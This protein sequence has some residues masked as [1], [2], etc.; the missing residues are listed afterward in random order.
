M[1]KEIRNG[2]NRVVF[3]MSSITVMAPRRGGG[4][5]DSIG[6]SRLVS[7]WVLLVAGYSLH[8]R[9]IQ[10]QNILEDS[11]TIAGMRYTVQSALQH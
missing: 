8:S 7:R 10:L 6:R 1:V 2:A 9:W 5:N 4:R 11:V 3:V